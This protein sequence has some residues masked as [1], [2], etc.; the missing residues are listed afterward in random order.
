[1][2]KKL[3]EMTPIEKVSRVMKG[4]TNED[5]EEVAVHILAQIVAKHVYVFED[6]EVYLEYLAKRLMEATEKY[7]QEHR[8]ELAMGYAFNKNE[9]EIREMLK[10]S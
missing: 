4:M 9:K 7:T 8:S 6:G 1:M 3:S 2:G 5:A 10:N